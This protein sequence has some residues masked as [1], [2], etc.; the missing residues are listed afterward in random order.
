MTLIDVDVLSLAEIE[1]IFQRDVLPL[2]AACFPALTDEPDASVADCC[3]FFDAAACHWVLC[4]DRVGGGG[5]VAAATICPVSAKEAFLA[6]VCVAPAWRGRRLASLVMRVA[7][8][9]L[10]QR[11]ITMVVGTVEQGDLVPLYARLGA[12]IDSSRS[13]SN[14]A[15][16]SFRMVRPIDAW[17]EFHAAMSEFEPDEAVRLAACAAGV[18]RGIDI[19][20]RSRRRRRL[21]VAA[22]TAVAVAA[23]AAWIWKTRQQR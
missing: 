16:T 15:A 17:A 22:V 10:M 18:W 2:L 11:G 3:G 19:D 4:R 8:A 23:A 21:A 6:N 1:P 7:Q 14:V 9:A 5:V 12:K 20:R 13:A